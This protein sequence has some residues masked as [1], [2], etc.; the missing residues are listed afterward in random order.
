MKKNFFTISGLLFLFLLNMQAQ[1][2]DPVKWN[3]T[4]EKLTNSTFNLIFK[5]TIEDK[6]HLYSQNIPE[7]GP[8]A[9]SF[10][11]D[12]Q[13][14]FKRIDKV[15]EISKAE[16]KFDESFGMNLKMFSHKAVFVQKIQ[17][18]NKD[19]FRIKGLL[20]FMC[21]DNAR[22]LPPKEIDFSFTIP[23]GERTEKSVK[24]ESSQNKESQSAV[25]T[26]STPEKATSI[27][28][29]TAQKIIQVVTPH[30]NNQAN[31]EEPKSVWGFFWYALFMGLLGVLTPCVYPMI[32]MT[33][34][35]FMRGE[36]NKTAGLFKGLTFGIS[37]IAIYTLI[38]VLVSLSILS[39]DIGNILSTHWIPNILFFALFVVFAASFFGMFEMV[40]PSSLVN[41]IDQQAEKG[42]FLGAFFMALTLV[43]VSF[44]CTGPIVGKILIEASRGLAL[45]PIAGMF[46]YS[47]AFALPFTLFAI[48][49]S[50]MKSLPKSGGWL[51]AVKVV[52]GFIVLAFSLTFITSID[53]SYHLNILS[54]E[55]FLII[56]IVIGVL[57]GF[58]LLG[59]IKFAHDSDL[60]YISTP[61]L[62]LVIIIFSFTL[63]LFTG[64]F[65]APLK[66][67][68]WIL[69]VKTSSNNIS[70]QSETPNQNKATTL[71]RVPK[72]ADILHLPN[73]LEGYFDLNEGLACAKE[74]NKPIFLD[75]KGHS[76][77]NCKEMESKVWSDARVLKK[78]SE[79][80]I[81]IALYVD[82]KTQLPENEWITSSYDG[83]VKKTL[84]A[85][86]L[87][88]E[89][90][91]YN[92]NTQPLYAILDHSGN[93]I[94]APMGMNLDIEAFLKFLDKGVKG[95]KEKR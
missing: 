25:Q 85:K 88:Y 83:K 84:G 29:D 13:V 15:N 4:V 54:R 58:Y 50:M 8:I 71:C 1:I 48:F 46:G 47:I 68:N 44:S 95:F 67:L 76:C 63:Y 23:A 82:D 78:L 39:A 14:N 19:E 74:K 21:C 79:E 34:S 87:D 53:Q 24:I 12:E 10:T 90:T 55:T 70:Q 92:T 93:T 80:F 36:Q 60:P 27:A 5:A 91:R 57:M 49:P 18:S 77:K 31:S 20:T 52:L 17:V 81:I 69:P 73:N 51:N 40:L 9:T 56:W 45:K 59:K 66:P 3:Y 38:G 22:C 43:I 89:I 33:V 6:W 26:P 37:I 30:A 61:R 94:S 32:P 16:N 2:A 64:L 62:F 41:K 11:F 75:I 35:F 86:N 42:G 72:Y 65:N 7:G 28:S